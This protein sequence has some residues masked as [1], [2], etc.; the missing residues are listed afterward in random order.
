M[1][2]NDAVGDVTEEGGKAGSQRHIDG[3]AAG[4]FFGRDMD[5]DEGD[6][7]GVEYAKGERMEHLAYDK[8]GFGGKE[9]EAE[10]TG[11]AEEEAGNRLGKTQ[12]AYQYRQIG[13]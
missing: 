1:F 11:R 8:D 10:Q 4:A 3:H 13:R 5:N 2:N 6:G 9:R 7:G 12:T